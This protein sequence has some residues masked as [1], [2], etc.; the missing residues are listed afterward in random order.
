MNKASSNPVMFS[1]IFTLFTFFTLLFAMQLTLSSC[2]PSTGDYPVYTREESA[3]DNQ[4][5]QDA[6]QKLTNAGYVLKTPDKDDKPATPYTWNEAFGLEITNDPSTLEMR[7][8]ALK[9]AK[10]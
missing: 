8:K 7:I 6:I 4:A 9:N 1:K 3:K 2:L 5:V 10:E